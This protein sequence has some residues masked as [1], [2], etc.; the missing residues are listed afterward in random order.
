[1]PHTKDIRKFIR[2]KEDSS[3]KYHVLHSQRIENALMQDLGLGGIRF[4]ASHFIPR[5]SLLKI[6]V[7]LKKAKKI[8]SAKV[9]TV[10]IKTLFANERYEIGATFIEIDKEALKFLHHYLSIH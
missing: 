3:I 5:N 1:M 6:E 8:I 4:F 9:K 2:L 10:W 7:A